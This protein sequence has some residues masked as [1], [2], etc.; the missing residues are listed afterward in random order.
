MENIIDITVPITE[1]MPVWPGS[2]RFQVTPV[3]QMEKG[4]SSNDSRVNFNLHTGT[5]IDAPRHFIQSGRT[6]E[7][8]SM[9]IFIG[10]C[11][12]AELKSVDKV[13][14][15]NLSAMDIPSDIERLLIKTKNSELWKNQSH[16]FNKDFVAFTKE[17][18]QWI[19]DKGIKLIGIDYLSVQRYYDGP[20]AHQILLGADIVA[21]EGLNLSNVEVGFYDLICLPMKL[22]NTEAAPVRVVLKRK[23]QAGD[24]NS[25]TGGAL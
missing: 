16:E 25:V 4:D 11:Y 2:R 23:C 17:G 9:D 18:A 22:V 21:L 19:V 20:E 14:P 5:H 3:K 7:Q 15:E 8:I 1:D 10:P 12:V 13:T 6:I 24:N